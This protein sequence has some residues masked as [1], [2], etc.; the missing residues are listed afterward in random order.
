VCL[1]LAYI[2]PFI[3]TNVCPKGRCTSWCIGSAIANKMNMFEKYTHRSPFIL[4]LWILFTLYFKISC[5]IWFYIF[6]LD[7]TLVNAYVKV[8]TQTLYIRNKNMYSL[9]LFC[10]F[11]SFV[12]LTHNKRLVLIVRCLNLSCD[13]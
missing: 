13:Q 10:T 6:V 9:T 12:C 8:N 1:G 3:C 11:L 5:C 4:F 2:F 7:Q